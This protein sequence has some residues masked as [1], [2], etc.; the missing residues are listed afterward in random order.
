MLAA[1]VCTI[2]GLVLGFAQS[3]LAGVYAKSWS[4][5]TGILWGIVCGTISFFSA[6]FLGWNGA[7]ITF[8]LPCVLGGLTVLSIELDRE[9]PP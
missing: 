4:G 9:R 8:L 1:F 3:L 7:Y 2:I 5:G 6:I